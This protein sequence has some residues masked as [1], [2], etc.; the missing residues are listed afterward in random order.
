MPVRHFIAFHRLG[1]F[2]HHLW[3]TL[4][5]RATLC[6][7]GLSSHLSASFP[8]SGNRHH[9]AL[10]PC[11][12]H[13]CI[14]FAVVFSVVFCRAPALVFCRALSYRFRV[15]TGFDV[16]FGLFSFQS[17]FFPL[18]GLS[19]CL[20][21]LPVVCS[22]FHSRIADSFTASHFTPFHPVHAVSGFSQ[23]RR[24][25]CLRVQSQSPQ[26]SSPPRK[27]HRNCICAFV[28]KPVSQPRR[29]RR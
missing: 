22:S 4:H 8:I 20:C 3:G 9:A 14:S 16:A 17:G 15:W 11:G 21:L 26:G 19:R 28:S 18:F 7:F 23:V 13:G 24:F 2:I 29:W 6:N 25:N 10:C 5:L 12:L 27:P 1:H